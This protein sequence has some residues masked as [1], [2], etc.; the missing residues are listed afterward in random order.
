MECTNHH[1][2]SDISWNLGLSLTG[3]A[4]QCSSWTSSTINLRDFGI[5]KHNKVDDTPSGGGPGLVI[6]P[7]VLGQQ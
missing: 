6:R 7:D 4:L 5:G 3:K 1:T 2:I